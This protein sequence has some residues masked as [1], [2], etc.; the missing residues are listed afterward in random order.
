[1]SDIEVSV[2]DFIPILNET[3]DKELM[4]TSLGREMI[5]NSLVEYILLFEDILDEDVTN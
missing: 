2:D 5:I 1:M 4:N 3:D